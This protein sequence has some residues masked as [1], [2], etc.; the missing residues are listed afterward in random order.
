MP[1]VY[2][3]VFHPLVVRGHY[4][5][6]AKNDVVVW[7]RWLDRH[8]GEF[9]AVAYDVAIGGVSIEVDDEQLDVALGF[10]YSSALRVD[11]LVVNATQAY[12]CEV[13]PH[14]TISAFG[15]AL[16][17]TLVARR[18]GVT[19]DEL[20]PAIICEAIQ[21]DVRWLCQQLGITV[22]EV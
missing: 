14:A 19:E 1:A 4:P 8:A 6:M 3:P 21:T 22:W 12:V 7:E 9:L 20:Q 2:P 5:H 18:D 17:Y 11:A 10:R 15:A 13:R 16:G